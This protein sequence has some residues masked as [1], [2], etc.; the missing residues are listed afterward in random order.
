M[1][2]ELIDHPQ[3]CLMT[4]ERWLSPRRVSILLCSTEERKIKSSYRYR[5]EGVFEK[6]LT[7]VLLESRRKPWYLGEEF[8]GP[9]NM[10]RGSPS[11]QNS[12][13]M[14]FGKKPVE[15]RFCRIPKVLQN[16][17]ARP[18]FSGPAN[19]SPSTKALLPPFCATVWNLM[20]NSLRMPSFSEGFKGATLLRTPKNDSQEWFWQ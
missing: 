7:I 5:L 19:S 10:G 8:A 16:L 4:R 18:S 20:R 2:Q 3:C 12:E 17:G 14:G 9:E 1:I 11:S 13:P 6:Q 15:E